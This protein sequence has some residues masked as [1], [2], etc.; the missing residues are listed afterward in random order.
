MT[1]QTFRTSEFNLAAFCLCN[2]AALKAIDK[3]EKRAVFELV[4]RQSPKETIDAFWA[5]APV[6]VNQFVGAQAEVKKRLFSDAF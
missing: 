4:F 2:G 3:T 5:D 6:P 1:L